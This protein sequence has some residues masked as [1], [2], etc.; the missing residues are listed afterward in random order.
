MV[1]GEVG[2]PIER[3]DI[4]ERDSAALDEFRS[5]YVASL[6]DDGSGAESEQPLATIADEDVE[7]ELQHLIEEIHQAG[8]TRDVSWWGWLGRLRPDGLAPEP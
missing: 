2:R 5:Q 8:S 6:V 1:L 3:T 4:I 7:E